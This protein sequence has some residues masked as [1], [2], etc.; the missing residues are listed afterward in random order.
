[1]V[2]AFY[3]PTIIITS[4]PS[5]SSSSPPETLTA[6]TKPLKRGRGREWRGEQEWKCGFPQPLLPRVH[7][8]T[9]RNSHSRHGISFTLTAF[10]ILSHSLTLFSLSLLT[11]F[12]SSHSL[13]I[14]HPVKRD[15]FLY[16][17]L[18]LQQYRF[19][20]L[21]IPYNIFSLLFINCFLLFKQ[22]GESKKPLP[23]SS[24]YFHGFEQPPTPSSHETL[25]LSSLS[26]FFVSGTAPL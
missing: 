23:S 25:S 16:L 4:L 2:A 24:L 12:H 20:L 3:R 11:C 9:V 6:G 8:L 17:S 19:L 1:M 5:S 26:L 10:T 13:R 21:S 22:E 14:V 18:H 7:P 15:I